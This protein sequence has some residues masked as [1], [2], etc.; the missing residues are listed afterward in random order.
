MA[1]CDLDVLLDRPQASYQPGEPIA[2]KVRVRVDADCRCNGLRLEMAWGTH[3]SG[4]VEG[5]SLGVRS[6][7]QGEWRAGQV[8]EYPF[9]L[10]APNIPYTYRG[11]HVNVDWTIEAQADIPWAIDPRA[12]ANFVLLPPS[13]GG[14]GLRIHQPSAQQEAMMKWFLPIFG[15]VFSTIFLGIPLFGAVTAFQAGW[16]PGLLVGGFC[17]V[18]LAIAVFILSKVFGNQLATLLVGKVDV[19]VDPQRGLETGRIPVH[20]QVNGAAR[21]RIRRVSASLVIQ[22][23]A[24]RGSGTD[25]QTFTQDLHRDQQTLAAPHGSGGGQIRYDGELALPNNPHLPYSFEGRKNWLE[26][27][28]VVEIDLPRWPD[29]KLPVPLVAYPEPSR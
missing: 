10:T 6:I 17:L 22:E 27:Q 4:T 13:T 2:G 26:W 25:R 7:W 3:G 20:V 14:L 1:R 23:R 24:E 19:T 21:K 15:V 8:R 29:Y 18:F 9:E 5:Q 16:I 12:Q 28:V 11:H